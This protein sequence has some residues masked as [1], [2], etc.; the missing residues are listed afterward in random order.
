M[1]LIC[2]PKTNPG[3]HLPNMK[4]SLKQ[5]FW[6]QKPENRL[7]NKDIIKNYS[8]QVKPSQTSARVSLLR[9]EIENETSQGFF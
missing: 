8:E 9:V 4:N 7:P 6:K 5:A 1:S 3:N 2:K